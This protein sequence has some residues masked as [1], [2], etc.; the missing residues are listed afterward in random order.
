MT[1]RSTKKTAAAERPGGGRVADDAE[2]LQKILARAGLASRREAEE[3]IRA[4][5]VSVNGEVATL[6]TRAHGQDQIRLDG[7]LVRRAP[8]K[9]A[10]TFLCHRSP[11]EPLLQ[12]GDDSTAEALASR[13]PRRVG[14][15]YL[16]ISPL[17]IADGGLELVTSDGSLAQAL[18]RRVRRLPIDFQLRVR[19]ELQSAQLDALLAGQLAGAPALRVLAVD[20]GGG[21]GANRWYMVQTV[22]ASAGDLRALVEQQGA[23]VSRLMRVRLGH[24][25]LDRSLSRGQVRALE[26]QDVAPLLEGGAE[27]DADAA[28]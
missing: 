8:V 10:A 7:R 22:G 6:G 20:A 3:W 13:L 14:R 19:G 16:A 9:Q 12:A 26:D 24:L 18:Q 4:G 5:R 25:A 11:G 21:E 2:R 28:G 15:R 1:R 17:P 27:A 23:A